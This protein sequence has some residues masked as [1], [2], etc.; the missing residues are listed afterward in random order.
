MRGFF[1][2]RRLGASIAVD[3]AS[4]VGSCEVDAAMHG[5]PRKILAVDLLGVICFDS[6]KNWRHSEQV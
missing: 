6:R 2:S 1:P 4:L 3:L 5:S